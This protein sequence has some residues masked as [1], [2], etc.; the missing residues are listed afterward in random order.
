MYCKIAKQA[1]ISTF[2]CGNNIK[3]CVIISTIARPSLMGC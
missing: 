2:A 1:I 3:R